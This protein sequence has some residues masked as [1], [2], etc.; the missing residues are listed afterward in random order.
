MRTILFI[1]QKEFIQI[2]RDKTMLPMIIL[3]PI[4]QMLILVNAATFELKNISI[5]VVNQD[6]SASSRQ[7]I[8]GFEGSKFFRVYY[9]NSVEHAHESLLNNS[10]DVILVIP[11][12]FDRDLTRERSASVQILINAIDGMAA[13]LINVYTGSIIND[14]RQDLLIQHME[15]KTPAEAIPV[16]ISHQFWYNPNLTYS[17]YM[18]PG[19]LVILV[20]IIGMFLTAINI[21]REKEN[22]TIEQINVTPIVKYQFIAGKLIPFLIIALFELAFGLLIGKLFFSLPILGSLWLLLLAA[23]LFLLVVLGLGLL[24][25]AISSTQQQVM[26]TIFFFLLVF[27]LMS[28]I[29]TPVES[30][31]GWAQTL[32]I[33]N[34]FTYFMQ[35][36]RMILLKGSGFKD[37]LNELVSLSVYAVIALGFAVW[38]Y[39]KTA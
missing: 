24:L 20:T 38:R 34:P 33:I 37:I 3:V 15:M 13:G 12:G 35:A 8:S 4:I 18:L 17:I 31:P 22:G 5:V 9:E 21:V 23:F 7:L 27:I 32:N 6:M 39:R 25:S 14:F 36:L 26:F 11:P 19:I 30:M 29:F 1:L 2:F 10:A 16:E 28:G